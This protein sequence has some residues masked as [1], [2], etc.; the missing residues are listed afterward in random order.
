MLEKIFGPIKPHKAS[1][2]LV[3]I[4]KG[5]KVIPVVTIDRLQDA[6][7]V[8]NA[9]LEG[10]LK[11]IELTLR[12][13]AAIE[14][15][16]KISSIGDITVGAGTMTSPRDVIECLSAGAK[17]GV[18]PGTTDQL[19]DACEAEGLPILGGVSSASEI[20]KLMTRG[21][22]V[23]KF[24]PAETSGG[25]NALRAISGPLP[26]IN[27][28]PTGGISFYKARGYLELPNVAAVGGSWI[29]TENLIREKNWKEIRKLASQAATLGEEL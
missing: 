2:Y 16:E 13:K 24:F 19:L 5:S 17:F 23:M 21:Y 3:D 26:Q 10:G 25:I 1:R 8:A 15:I 14:A 28:C 4:V 27:F 12:T 7:P 18:S 9:L 11:V 22:T 20:M 29:A 6:E